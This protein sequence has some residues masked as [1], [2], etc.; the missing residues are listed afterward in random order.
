[1]QTI[2]VEVDEASAGSRL[3]V[4]LARSLPQFSRA[5]LQ[6]LV[7]EGFL[8][9]C[10]RPIADPAAR[11]KPGDRF[12]LVVPDPTPAEPRPQP[13]PLHI[14]YEDEHLLVLVKPAGAVVHPAPGHPAGTLVNALLAHC[15]A[16]LSGIGGVARPGIVHRLDR[17]VSGVL[18]AAKHD[19]AHLGLAAQFT[20]HSIERIYEGVVRGVPNPPAGTIDRPIGRDPRDR[21]RMAVV[22]GGKRAVSHYRVLEAA[23]TLASR[24]EVRLE[25]GRTHQ[26]RVHLAALGHPLLG[27]RL[28]GSRRARD[29][30]VA[31]VERGLDRILLHARVLG[32]VHPVS[33]ERMRFEVPPPALFAEVV[34]RL[35]REA[36]QE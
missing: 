13:L 15:G 36:G 24:L 31:A 25:T 5:R 17:D 27:D 32:F 28:Y 10:E 12:E 22:A 6:A 9:T 4:F 11:V 7:R 8:R 19:R 1:M 18:V 3:D 21:K 20:V 33:G 2:H 35:R 14:L 30:A 34:H 23:G 29:P 16:S 26:I